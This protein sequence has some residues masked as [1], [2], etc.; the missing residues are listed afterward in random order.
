MGKLWRGIDAEIRGPFVSLLIGAI[1]LG[2]AVNAGTDFLVQKIGRLWTVALAGAATGA[3]IV[4]AR[5]VRSLGRVLRSLLQ[6]NVLEVGG[7]VRG[8]QGL[9]VLASPE[10]GISSAEA[11]IRYHL[12]AG[13]LEH[14]RLVTGGPGSETSAASLIQKLVGEGV[15]MARFH[16]LPLDPADADNPEAVYRRINQIYEEAEEAGL[17][18][19]EIIGDYTGGTKSMTAGM[20]LACTAP[21]RHLQFMD[22]PSRGSSPTPWP[23]RSALS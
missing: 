15:P 14:C 3:I 13:A 1:T 4:L 12:S 5:P 16:P 10:P 19:D 20:I 21:R 8:H 18:E 11:A 22:A 23:S 6:A 9:I 17:R 2:I 7:P